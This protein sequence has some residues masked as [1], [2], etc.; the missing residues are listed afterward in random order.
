[1]SGASLPCPERELLLH[2]LADGELDAAN[3]L[4][5]E[6]HMR[7]C[8]GCAAAHAEILEK[9]ALLRDGSSR[10]SAPPGLRSRVLQA[11]AAQKGVGLTSAPAR[12]RK[13]PGR[14]LL[15]YAGAAVSGM[16]LAA[17]I[18][19]AL[20]GPD[21]ALSI[22]GQLAA[23]HVRSLLAS[24]LTD[25]AS[26]DRHTVKPWFLG[27]LGFAPPVR[28]LEQQDFPLAGGRLDYIGG[29]VVPAL[30]YR[31]RGHVINLFIW[32]SGKMRAVP[33]TLDGYHVVIWE[34]DGFS[35]AAVSDLDLPGLNECERAFQSAAPK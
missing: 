31:R 27:K 32:P 34:R 26:S 12:K 8:E 19:L 14:L 22:D 3:T 11:I 9:S 10:F 21:A 29:N 15:G 25:V 33:A 24:H 5:M 28:D 1:M 13:I 2:G 16:A 4:A 7:R 17:S 30:V 23:S 18:V 35:F 20:M 6:E